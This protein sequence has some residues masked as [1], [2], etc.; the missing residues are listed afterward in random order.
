M[1]DI[2]MHLNFLNFFV[3]QWAIYTFQTLNNKNVAFCD[4]YH[5]PLILQWWILMEFNVTMG[6]KVF[7]MCV[8]FMF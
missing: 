3:F 5:F 1:K 4:Y 2:H 6:F 8:Y 7:F